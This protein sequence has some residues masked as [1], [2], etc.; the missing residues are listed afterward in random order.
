MS[1]KGNVILFLRQSKLQGNRDTT[2]LSFLDPVVQDEVR[3]SLLKGKWRI[4][5]ELRKQN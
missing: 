5:A 4:F 1:E 2:Y 3:K